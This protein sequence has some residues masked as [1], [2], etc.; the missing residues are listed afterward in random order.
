MLCSQ[1]VNR[2]VQSTDIGLTPRTW[3]TL[4]AAIKIDQIYG[5]LRI[6]EHVMRI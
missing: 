1:L 3:C 5:T 6:N 4:R 2:S